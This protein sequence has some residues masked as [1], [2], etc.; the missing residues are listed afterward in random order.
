M[1]RETR[2]ELPCHRVILNESAAAENLARCHISHEGVAGSRRS[3]TP[4]TT[5]PPIIFIGGMADA[6]AP[7]R[8]SAAEALTV[9]REIAVDSGRIVLIPHAKKRSAQRSISRRQVERCCQKGTITEGPYPNAKGR[10]RA[11]LY[12]H[13]AGEEVKCVVAI[14]SAIRLIVITAFCA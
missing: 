9:I 7:S 10:W 2:S 13:A 11:T 14:Q 1:K 4:L 8:L 5:Y 3:D 12:R 6:V